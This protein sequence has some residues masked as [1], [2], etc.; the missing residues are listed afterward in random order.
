M[1]EGPMKTA[2]EESTAGVIKQE[3]VTYVVDD[4]N[5]IIKKTVTRRFTMNGDYSDSVT[6][7]PL[8]W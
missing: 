5:R 2:M 3:F 4:D 1:K 8:T 6:S 7:E